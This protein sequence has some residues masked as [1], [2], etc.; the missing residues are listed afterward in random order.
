MAKRKPN[1]GIAG[2]AKPQKPPGADYDSP[3][4]EALDRY[5]E[6][7]LAF[8][9]PRIHAEIDWTRGYETLDKELQ[10]IVRGAGHGRRYV[11]KLVKVWLKSGEERWLLIHI[12]VQATKEGEFPRRMYVYNHR[13]FDRYNQ[14][15]ISLAILADDDPSWQPRSYGYSRW[16]F[17]VSIEFPVVKLLDYT[18]KYEDL[19]A[20]PNPFA[21]VVLAHLKAL[22]TRRS[23]DDRRAWKVRLVKGLEL[24]EPLEQS[25]KAEIEALNRETHMRFRNVFERDALCEGLLLGIEKCLRMKFGAESLELMPEPRQ[26]Y[27]HVLLEKILDRIETADSPAALRRY[28]TRK[29]RAKKAETE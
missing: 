15:V 28:W 20:D 23:P 16:G 9:F 5:F 13:I 3:W 8:F 10:P 14:E 6:L 21:V 25:F 18:A 26:I 27:D 22:E 12:E 2:R 4:K 7:F 24:P 19:E 1:L 29:R 11:D 17:R